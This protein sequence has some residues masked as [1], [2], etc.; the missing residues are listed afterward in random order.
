MG[1]AWQH[2]AFGSEKIGPTIKEMFPQVEYSTRFF[3]NRPQPVKYKEKKFYIDNITYTD[4][5]VFNVFTIPLIQGNPET[6][7]SLLNSAVITEEMALKFFGETNPMGKVLT[8]DSVDFRITG[9]MENFP[10]QHS[11]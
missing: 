11:Y 10:I 3:I 8:I 6:S 5:D 4:E 7:L 1:Q 2:C 9:V